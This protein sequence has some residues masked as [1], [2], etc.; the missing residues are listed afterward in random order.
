MRKH[1]EA[2]SVRVDGEAY[3]YLKLMAHSYGQSI[4]DPIASLVREREHKKPLTFRFVCSICGPD[5]P[6]EYAVTVGSGG[7]P[8][9]LGPT[10]EG[11]REALAKLRKEHGYNPRR[12]KLQKGMEVLDFRDPAPESRQ[13]AAS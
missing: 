3:K 11:A 12:F 8:L 1:K 2:V 7:D 6:N 9:W 4:T 10:F 13:E 5:D